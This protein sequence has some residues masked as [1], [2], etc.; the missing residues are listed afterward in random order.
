M[1]LSAASYH[2]HSR[3]PDSRERDNDIDMSA[4]SA[5]FTALEWVYAAFETVQ[6]NK[7]HLAGVLK[8][9]EIV[10][11]SI[12]HVMRERGEVQSDVVRLEKLQRSFQHIAETMTRIGKRS[13]IQLWLH[14]GDDG[15][16]IEGCHHMITDLIILFNL[17]ELVDIN[18][19]NV[20]QSAR[21]VIE[22]NYIVQNGNR[23]E[24][25]TKQIQADVI[26]GREQAASFASRAEGFMRTIQP[27]RRRSTYV[28]D[29][30]T[31]NPPL[32]LPQ[33]SNSLRLPQSLAAASIFPSYQ[34]PFTL[35]SGS[36]IVELISTEPSTLPSPISASP[37][38]L[39]QDA[40]T[41]VPDPIPHHAPDEATS[42]PL[43][44]DTNTSIRS[45]STTS[46][47]RRLYQTFPEPSSSGLPR[48]PET[49][50]DPAS[51]YI[52]EDVEARTMTMVSDFGAVTVSDSRPISG[53]VESSTPDVVQT[54]LELAGSSPTVVTRRRSLPFNL[55][56]QIPSPRRRQNQNS[57]QGGTT[58]RTKATRLLPPEPT[59]APPIDRPAAP[60]R[61]SQ[62]RLLPRVPGDNPAHA[63]P[64]PSRF[65]PQPFTPGELAYLDGKL[66]RLERAD[67]TSIS[68]SK[69][70]RAPKREDER[71]GGKPLPKPLPSLPILSAH[72]PNTDPG[73]DTGD[74][75]ETTTYTPLLVRERPIGDEMGIGSARVHS[76]SH[77]RLRRPTS[78]TS[79]PPP[80][81]SRQGSLRGDGRRSR[82]SS[83]PNSRQGSLRRGAVE[84]AAAGNYRRPSLPVLQP[85]QS[86]PTQA[87]HP[88]AQISVGDI[89]HGAE[90]VVEAGPRPSALL[91]T[92]LRETTLDSFSTTAMYDPDSPAASV[93]EVPILP[94]PSTTPAPKTNGKDRMRSIPLRDGATNVADEPS[95]SSLSPPMSQ[96]LL[97]P[98]SKGSRTIVNRESADTGT[99]LSGKAKTRSP[100]ASTLRTL[101]SRPSVLGMR[102]AS[103]PFVSSRHGAFKYQTFAS[104]PGMADGARDELF[105]VYLLAR[106]IVSEADLSLEHADLIG[107]TSL[108]VLNSWVHAEQSIDKTPP[109]APLS[110]PLVAN[111]FRVGLPR[112]ADSSSSPQGVA[113]GSKARERAANSDTA[114]MLCLTPGTNPYS[115]L[116]PLPEADAQK[117]MDEQATSGSRKPAGIIVLLPYYD[118]D[119][120]LLIQRLAAPSSY[121]TDMNGGSGEP[122]V[123]ARRLVSAPTAGTHRGIKADARARV[124]SFPPPSLP[125]LDRA[126]TSTS[127]TA[128]APSS[129]RSAS[130][131]L[132]SSRFLARKFSLKRKPATSAESLAGSLTAPRKL[133]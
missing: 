8:R 108:A 55:R 24:Q 73:V 117:L 88:Q 42:V 70:K 100:G 98:D 133:S 110:R 91:P 3:S 16:A 39:P 97:S 79:S 11:D 32:G 10:V 34:E 57:Q 2:P 83:R 54:G 82:S 1:P 63:A 125:G 58:Q 64:V 126:T 118:P 53:I 85:Q 112:P 36:K 93:P 127:T 33:R 76:R 71:K 77:L 107:H 103:E 65:V 46:T 95:S 90:K 75:V 121:E 124:K 68:I 116:R 30:P 86:P 111:H 113:I 13:W 9:C 66:N 115:I 17:H 21:R 6:S 31:M 84:N 12:S 20:H 19:W 94:D 26:A 92:A 99:D 41:L 80:A 61:V 129:S 7:D 62:I 74:R 43:R 59:V 130:T 106:Q 128:P 52:A 56:I 81:L 49:S 47:V 102:R 89:N 35:A 25:R 40:D 45:A 14:S 15:V 38:N 87:S 23:I 28:R 44:K 105:E 51:R 50:P 122:A 109:F 101:V 96:G 27:V 29:R 22:H 18:Q 72:P 37:A 78:E 120:S 4:L 69:S 131:W 60:R 132:S 114:I 67:P 104:T 123:T 119:Q 48:V 5:A